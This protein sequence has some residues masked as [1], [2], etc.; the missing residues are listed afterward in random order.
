MIQDSIGIPAETNQRIQSPSVSYDNPYQTPTTLP[1]RQSVGSRNHSGSRPAQSQLGLLQASEGM[2]LATPGE[3]FRARIM[4]RLL[5]V[6]VILISIAPLH[7]HQ[8]SVRAIASDSA[9]AAI[10]LVWV[11]GC[12]VVYMVWYIR[13]L[14][15][16]KTPG[17]QLI[18]I[19]VRD[20]ETGQPAG[21]LQTGLIREFLVHI[22]YLIPLVGLIFLIAEIVML[23]Q[24]ERRTPRDLMANTSVVR[25]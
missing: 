14:C 6:L 18:G 23:F 16:G 17:K 1:P 7:L 21:F 15:R 24:P 13:L 8:G 3:R 20:L 25:D 11:L 9:I 5:G 22:I 10:A 12:P 2:D 4:D 19:H